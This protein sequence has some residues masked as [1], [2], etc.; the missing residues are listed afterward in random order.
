MKRWI[1]ALVVLLAAL[2]G[3]WA[4]GSPYLTLFQLKRE[5][6]ANDLEAISARVEFPSVRRSLKSELR[7]RL[8]H[9]DD[10]GLGAIGA[11]IAERLSDPIVDTLVTPEGMRT[12]FAS[13]S[14]AQA[15]QPR[16]LET[17]A[18]QMHVR[19]EAFGRFALTPDSGR[20]PELIFELRGLSWMVT[21]VR[22]PAGAP[23]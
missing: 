22:L 15:A 21:G 6:D 18:K 23:L 1:I 4:W 16:P 12:V 3:G 8:G 10:A 14:V 7:N 19:R 2:A 20:G 9:G 11:A 13:A 17:N 5:A